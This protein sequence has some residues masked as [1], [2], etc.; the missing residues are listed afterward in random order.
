MKFKDILP[1]EEYVIKSKLSVEQINLRLNEN[2]EPKSKSIFSAFSRNST[3]PYEGELYGNRF[4]ISRII[5][6]KNSFLPIISGDIFTFKDFTNINVKME[7]NKTIL[8]IWYLIVVI[9]GFVITAFD[10]IFNSLSNTNNFPFGG[11]EFFIFIALF[12]V[13]P[14]IAFKIESRKSKRF[15]SILLEETSLEI[16]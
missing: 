10:N 1:F 12:I 8:V 15:L 3:K 2:I 14:L 7:T 6:Y 16:F 9:V 11:N 4:K 13:T 5:N